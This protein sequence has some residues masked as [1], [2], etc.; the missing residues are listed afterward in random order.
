MDQT[1]TGILERGLPNAVTYDLT[2]PN[3]VTIRLP[4]KSTWSSGL[5]WHE[6]HTEY[7][8]VINGS[9]K[10]RLGDAEQIVTANIDNQPEIKIE[11]YAWHEWQRAEPDGDEV[12]VVERTDPEDG[13]KAIFF[14]NING[15]TLNAKRVISANVPGF[16]LFPAS[17]KDLMI[18]FWITLNLFIVFHSMDN[19][20]VRLDSQ[21]I[22]QRLMSHYGLHTGAGR[23]TIV[24]ITIGK[25]D[26]SWSLDVA[27][28][29][30]A[31]NS[32]SPQSKLAQSWLQFHTIAIG[33]T[34]I[35][36]KSLPESAGCSGIRSSAVIDTIMALFDIVQK[37]QG[38]TVTYHESLENFLL[39]LELDSQPPQ[40]SVWLNCHL[41]FAGTA[42]ATTESASKASIHNLSLQEWTVTNEYGNITVP[43]KFPSQAHL[44]LYAAG[45]IDD[46][47]HGLNDF[48][49]RWI[50]AQ[51]WT[52]TSNPMIG[53]GLRNKQ[54]SIT[55][56]LV[57]DGLDTY[58]TVKF[59]DHIVGTPDN[60]FRQ[61][62]YDVSSVLASC[63]SD[64]VLSINFG[65]VPRIINAINAS[66]EV[67]HWPAPVVY[68]FEYPNRQWVRKEQNDFGWDWGPAFSPVGPW[69][70]GRIVQLS[71]GGELYSLNTDIDIFRKGQSNNFAPDQSA[72]WVV[73]ASLDFLGRLPKHASMSVLITDVNDSHSVLYSGSLQG[74]TQ[75]D[76]TVT[77]SVTI[78]A[79]RPKLWWPRDMGNQQL[80]NIIVSVS[81]AGSR[82]PLLV[83]QRRVGFRTILFS[84]GN[85]TDAQIA[86]GITPGNNWHFEVNG[87][88]FY[89]KGA[90]LIP[91]DSFWPRVASD[92]INRL[93]DSVEAQNFNM[94]RVWSSGAYLPDW[95][96]DIADERGVLLWSEFQFSDTLYPDSPDFKANVVGEITYNVRRLNHHASLAC[97]MGGNEF[98]NLML[99]IAQV[100][101][102][103]TYPYILGQYED[104]F[105][106]TIF[107][108][109]AANSHSISYSPCSA[110]NGWLEIDLDLPVPIVERYYNTTTGH[111]YGDTDFYDYDTSV[112]FDTSVYPVGRFANEF[113]FISMPSIQTWQQAVDPEDLHFNSTT[114]IL[115]N[116]HYP[117]GGL[118]RNIR[119]STLG[120]VEMTLAVERYYPTPDKT[121]SAAN[122][123]SWCHAT[124]LF[125]ADM[126]KSEIQFYRRGSGLPERQLGSLYWQLNDIWQ[127]PT[128]AGLEYDGRWKVLPYVSRRTYEHVIASAFWNY[129]T[130]QLEIWVISDLWESVSGQVSLT[131]VHLSGKAIANNAGMPKSIKFDVGA[132]NATQIISAN[133]KTDLKIPDTSDAVL[134]IELTAKAGV[135]GF[136]DDNAFVLS[137]GEKKEV[138]FTL[139]Q[140][141]TGGRW[142]EQVT[143]ES[144]W[145][146]TT[147]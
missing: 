49:L 93:F 90:N 85:V 80:Y 72:P 17:I 106:T 67:Q 102:P 113:G 7:L 38:M 28:K 87:H 138:V 60:Q 104:L 97:W 140:D 107:N 45:V 37:A 145:D 21:Q 53:F 84:S 24:L 1:T 34:I 125:Q 101:D 46:P 27:L 39:R 78:D 144:L 58:A 74:V 5:H 12:V 33:D 111:I 119:N 75:S 142:T 139:Q 109:L 115:R 103:E 3:Q 71:K 48:D 43:G 29:S 110:N 123:S 136:F 57:F 146:L 50:A 11:R 32:L 61:W 94:L 31:P 4:S 52:Y 18:D 6:T 83:S 133:V 25:K 129:T 117:A 13:E 98:E 82:M 70:P 141:T 54:P 20:P 112:S 73:N 147:P 8:K 10:V 86:S 2:Q 128:W 100:A 135:L 30:I 47:Y 76:M 36:G 92:R 79:K 66:D 127:A 63:K 19:F 95:I 16:S 23:M 91:P 126:Y 137:P 62:F 122:F 134:I 15:I 96:Y 118:S 9:I 81:S 56:W 41:I 77:G 22:G 51:N 121:D 132:I 44:D 116:H 26:G 88:E 65:S 14:W 105:I 143:A 114:V 59:C 64:P 130:N 89:A 124:Q 68:P 35:V 120:Q 42:V 108:V 131:W 99:P 69:Q 40:F 55:T